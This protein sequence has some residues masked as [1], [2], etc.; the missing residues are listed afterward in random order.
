[1]SE[2]RR[3]AEDPVHEAVCEIIS[4]LSALNSYADPIPEERL[5][6][7]AKQTRYISETDAMVKHSVE[8][9]HQ[10]I[11]FLTH[12]RCMRDIYRE[13]YLKLAV[14]PEQFPEW[15]KT[16]CAFEEDSNEVRNEA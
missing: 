7:Y 3:T 10:A 6:S 16:K 1:M 11:T 5:D 12:Q 4:G 14:F 8:H 9:F 2:P 13:V 15:L